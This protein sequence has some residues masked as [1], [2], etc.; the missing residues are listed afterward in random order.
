MARVKFSANMDY[1]PKGA[2]GVVIAYKAGKT[3]PRV[4]EEA[5]TQAEFEG[6]G[7]RLEPLPRPAEGPAPKTRA[8]RAQ[9]TRRRIARE[10]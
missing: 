7:V 5:A 9:P 8:R 1:R 6:A 2:P 4:K 10:P 3:Y